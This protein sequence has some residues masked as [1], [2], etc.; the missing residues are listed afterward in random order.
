M[1]RKAHKI[2]CTSKIFS[3]ERFCLILKKVDRGALK[4]GAKN[5]EKE[6][7]SNQ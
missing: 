3:P 7:S 1:E 5:G 2:C 4:K 6:T